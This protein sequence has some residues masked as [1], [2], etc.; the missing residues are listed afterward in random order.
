PVPRWFFTSRIPPLEQAVSDALESEQLYRS[1]VLAPD[2]FG[3]QPPTDGAYYHTEGV[4][5]MNFLSAPFYLFDE[6]DQLDKI[7]QDS[8]VPLTRATIRVV[9][10]TGDYSAADLRAA[11]V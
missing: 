9:D 7:D 1:M 4:P 6:M 2:A 11:V 10:F 8:L 5:V 3:D